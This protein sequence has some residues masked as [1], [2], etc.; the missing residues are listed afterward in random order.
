MSED[1]LRSLRTLRTLRTLRSLRPLKTIL[2]SHRVHIVLRRF[3]TPRVGFVEGFLCHPSEQ[4]RSLL[5]ANEE[6]AMCGMV[7]K[8][9][10]RHA[11]HEMCSTN[12][13]RSWAYEGTESHHECWPYPSQ[14]TRGARSP[15]RSHCEEPSPNDGCQDTT[16]GS[17]CSYHALR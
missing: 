6:V 14:T 15:S 4:L 10:T 12:I 1:L 13:R 8:A 3:P 17:P 5:T 16:R 2:N 7:Q 11:R 9:P